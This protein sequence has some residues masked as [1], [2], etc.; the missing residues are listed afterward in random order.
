MILI[1]E[2]I[3]SRLRTIAVLTPSWKTRDRESDG[4]GA[5]LD[6]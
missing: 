6:R 5:G 4:Y 3:A 2:W 1:G